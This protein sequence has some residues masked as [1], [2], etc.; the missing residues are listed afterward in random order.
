MRE[1]AQKVVNDLEADARTELKKLELR[2]L[3]AEEAQMEAEAK[4]ERLS[5]QLSETELERNEAVSRGSTMDN[6]LAAMRDKLQRSEESNGRLQTQL[7]RLKKQ[8]SATGEALF[9]K[10]MQKRLSAECFEAAGL[11]TAAIKKIVALEIAELEDELVAERAKPSASAKELSAELDAMKSDFKQNHLVQNSRQKNVTDT[12]S[13]L[14]SG[15]SDAG[16]QD[17]RQLQLRCV[18]VSEILQED[19]LKEDAHVSADG[20]PFTHVE[21]EIMRLQSSGSLR[22]ISTGSTDASPSHDQS[23]LKPLAD[24]SEYNA[25]QV[26]SSERCEVSELPRQT[27]R[28]NTFGRMTSWRRGKKRNT[29][30]RWKQLFSLHRASRLKNFPAT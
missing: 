9:A 27:S 15:R 16:T 14:D 17:W 21:Q 24:A 3:K 25:D 29:R 10:Q 5:R 13:I 28:S 8:P 20:H 11:E 30:S 22:R 18:P 6:E 26:S 4:M 1:S 23:V 12:T 19:L 2:C 7:A